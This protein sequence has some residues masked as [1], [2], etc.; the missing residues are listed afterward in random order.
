MNIYKKKRQ[1]INMSEVD[2]AKKLGMDLVKYKFVEKGLMKMPNELIDKFNKIIDDGAINKIDELE[3]KKEVESWFEENFLDKNK[4]NDLLKFYNIENYKQLG[5]L[6]G[7]KDGSIISGALRKG[8]DNTRYNFKNKVYTF[9]TNEMNIQLPVNTRNTSKKAKTKTNATTSSERS[10]LLEWFNNFDLKQFASENNLNPAELSRKLGISSSTAWGLLNTQ[11]KSGPNTG[12]LKKLKNLVENYS[13][14]DELSKEFPKIPEMKEEDNICELTIQCL[15]DEPIVE[16][17]RP[18]YT[19]SN[20]INKYK[21]MINEI[22][23]KINDIQKTMSELET[24]KKIY[25]E[26]LKELELIEN[27]Q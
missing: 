7:Y 15:A 6:L 23:D 16:R 26:V 20:T 19:I 2:M 11:S 22:D 21:N 3:H 27:E 25:S 5:I 24:N 8:S 12:T 13:V 17:T 10:E 9:L 14:L 4:L 18:K 1:K